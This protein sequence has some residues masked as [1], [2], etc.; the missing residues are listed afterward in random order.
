MRIR[1]PRQAQALRDALP[2]SPSER[3]AVAL[4]I[5]VNPT[6]LWRWLTGRQRPHARQRAA[7]TNYLRAAGQESRGDLFPEER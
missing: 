4:A 1:Y 6:T 3:T 2:R 7:L 5:G